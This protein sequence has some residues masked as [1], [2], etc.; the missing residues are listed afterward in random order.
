MLFFWSAVH[1][2]VGHTS[3]LNFRGLLGPQS[4]YESRSRDTGSRDK[5]WGGPGG[6][7]ALSYKAASSGRPLQVP[8]AKQGDSQVGVEWVF[9][10]AKGTQQNLGVNV[11]RHQDLPMY[12]HLSAQDLIP[13][14]SVPH[15]T[16]IHAARLGIPLVLYRPSQG[17]ALGLLCSQLSSA[18]QERKL[19]GADI[20]HVKLFIRLGL[21]ILALVL[22]FPHLSGAAGLPAN[23]ILLISWTTCS[24]V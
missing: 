22:S 23:P 17:G 24:K 14:W 18:L 2:L 10:S 9:L 7:P 15:V 3:F 6:E 13:F 5:W 19:L 1:R 11:P 8:R 4:N 21:H 20:E 12:P 16:G